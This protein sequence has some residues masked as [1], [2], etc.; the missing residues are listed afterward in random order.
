MATTQKLAKKVSILPTQQ[1]QQQP[2]TPPF[3]RD[4]SSAHSSLSTA[5]RSIKKIHEDSLRKTLD[6]YK[7]KLIKTWVPNQ[8]I[9]V[10]ADFYA[11]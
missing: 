10:Y 4:D 1:Q 9:Y 2:S 11:I 6:E 3:S 8:L 7:D 5:D